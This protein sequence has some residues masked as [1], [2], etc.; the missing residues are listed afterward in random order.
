MLSRFEN[1]ITVLRYYGITVL[2]YYG[3]AVLRY[4]DIT[5]T[6]PLLPFRAGVIPSPD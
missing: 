5:V 6:R 4:Y 3:I 1:P 2:R